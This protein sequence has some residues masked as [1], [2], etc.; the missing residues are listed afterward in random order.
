[1]LENKDKTQRMVFTALFGA[2]SCVATWVIRIP[3]PLGGYLNLGDGLVLLCG[4]CLGGW[5]GV[6]AAGIGSMMADFFGGY[7]H[8]MPATLL[9]KAF[10]AATAGVLYQVIR[11][12]QKSRTLLAATVSG[13]VAELFMLLGYY[14]FALIFLREG[15][16]AALTIPGN[17]IQG[18][19]G[20]VLGMALLMALQKAGVAD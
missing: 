17:A 9:I 6:S 8:Y 15:T 5:Y 19:A 14:L 18:C 2:L 4:F 10:M 7:L 3:S 16:A 12:G 13:I 1:M 20:I 11:K